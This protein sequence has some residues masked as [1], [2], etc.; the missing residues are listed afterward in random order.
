M[1]TFNFLKQAQLYLVHDSKRYNIDIENVSFSQTFTETSYSVK[2][3]HEQNMFEAS[4]INKANAANFEFKIPVLRESDFDVVYSRL[5]DYGTVDLYLSTERDVFKLDYCVFT[6]GT[7]EIEKSKPLSM[8]IQGE[9]SKLSKVGAADSYTIPGTPQARTSSR[10]FNTAFDVNVV[11]GG[12]NI[13]TE[14]FRISVELQND[15]SWVPYTTV[16]G[17]QSATDASTSMYPTDFVVTK[18]VLAGNIGR[19]ITDSNADDLQ[20]WNTDTTL[21]IDVGQNVG[22][23]INGFHFNIPNCTFTNRMEVQSVFTQSYDWR[24]TSNPTALSSV[25]TY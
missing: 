13:S 8:T 22:G 11:L 1:A 9:A 5:L 16:Q 18:R 7:L 15:I 19:Y 17:A 3:L 25:I 2:D 6:N 20:D 21:V 4:V 24:M 14:V 23:T 10:T 12:S